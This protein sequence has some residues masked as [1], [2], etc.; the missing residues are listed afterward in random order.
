MM[1]WQAPG[2]CW[3]PPVTSG[4]LPFTQE[5][6]EMVRNKTNNFQLLRNNRKAKLREQDE[7]GILI[8]DI[9]MKKEWKWERAELKAQLGQTNKQTNQHWLL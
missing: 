3:A 6:G 8:L 2:V 4:I 1:M 5:Q 9:L 7:I